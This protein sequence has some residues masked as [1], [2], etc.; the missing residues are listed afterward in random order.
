[1]NHVFAENA[2]ILQHIVDEAAQKKNIAA[3]PQWNPDVGHG[4]GAGETGIDVNNSGALFAGLNHPLETNW[5]LFG[6]GR[7]HDQNGIGVS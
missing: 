7:S 1:M 5:M 6:H 2:F 4:R 3:R